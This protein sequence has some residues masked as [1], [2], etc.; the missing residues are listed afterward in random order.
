MG[1]NLKKAIEKAAALACDSHPIIG[2]AQFTVLCMKFGNS[3][4]VKD[5]IV[6]LEKKVSKM[7]DFDQKK[8]SFIEERS[9]FSK[10]ISNMSSEKDLI[11]NE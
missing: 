6:F 11:R 3:K 10:L 5:Q 4:L 1:D 7:I 2:K 9:L 8:S